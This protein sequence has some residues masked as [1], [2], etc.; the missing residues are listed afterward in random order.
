[1]LMDVPY[2]T[3]QCLWTAKWKNHTQLENEYQK[4]QNHIYSYQ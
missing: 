3:N 1:M 4:D 2:S